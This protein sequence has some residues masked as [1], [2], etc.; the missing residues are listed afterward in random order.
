M[1]GRTRSFAGEI[2]QRVDI[3]CHF[4]S[5]K[6]GLAEQ[7]SA[8]APAAADESCF[9]HLRRLLNCRFVAK[10]RIHFDFCCSRM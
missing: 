8:P 5:V 1:C 6:T 3:S 2:A 10:Q 9:E 4:G 7:E